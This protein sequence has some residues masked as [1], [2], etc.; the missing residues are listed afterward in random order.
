MAV[1]DAGAAFAAFFGETHGRVEGDGARVVGVD[2]E[3]DAAETPRRA[4]VEGGGHEGPAHAKP[5][6]SCEHAHAQL[7]DVTEFRPRARGD[8]VAPSNDRT[9]GQGG[10]DVWVSDGQVGA[11]EVVGGPDAEALGGG[12]P[13]AFAGDGV[14]AIRNAG[15]VAGLHVSDDDVGRRHVVGGD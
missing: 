2:L 11:D 15:G 7:A 5:T 4:G 13:E 1:E 9:V 6:P 10:D 8:D 12:Q 3:F 14:D